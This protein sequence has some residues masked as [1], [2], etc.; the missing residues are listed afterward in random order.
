MGGGGANSSVTVYDSGGYPVE[1]ALISPQD[2]TNKVS[3]VMH[4][5]PTG[6]GFQSIDITL[7]NVNGVI[8]GNGT[9]QVLYD[10]G[11]TLNDTHGLASGSRT[12]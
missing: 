9:L 1:Q 8:G 4:Q 5:G 11:S 10:N 7:R 3:A 12:P 2:L 6:A